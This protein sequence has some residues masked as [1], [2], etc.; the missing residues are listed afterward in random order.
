M[1]VR[2]WVM[3]GWRR[4][5]V[6]N[7]FEEYDAAIFEDLDL[8]RAKSGDEIVSQLFHFRDRGDR[9]FALRPEMTPTLARMIA[10]R[11]NSLPRPIKA[12]KR[13]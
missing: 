9:E 13:L 11:A 5:S 1:A 12:S 7:G 8:Y 4:V 2:N 6:R 3:D 10:A